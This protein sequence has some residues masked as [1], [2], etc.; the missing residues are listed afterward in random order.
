[1]D[2]LQEPKEKKVIGTARSCFYAVGL[3]EYSRC[4]G[5]DV[6]LVGPG[7]CYLLWAVETEH[8]LADQQFR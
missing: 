5:Y 2:S 1:M 7:R 8:G 4:E 6:Y 3:A